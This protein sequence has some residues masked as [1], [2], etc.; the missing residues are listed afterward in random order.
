MQQVCVSRKA[1]EFALRGCEQR[2]RRHTKDAIRPT[3]IQGAI[4]RRCTLTSLLACTALASLAGSSAAASGCAALRTRNDGWPVSTADDDKLVDSTALC[5]MADRLA[6]SGANNPS[7]LVAHR[8]NL[9]FDRYFT[10]SD[11]IP[12]SFS[13][14]AYGVFRD[15]LQATSFPG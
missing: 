1:D 2:S 14:P 3:T 15:V 5:A 11:E 4:L 6:T 12:L 9:V 10:G 7:V 13:A 8:G